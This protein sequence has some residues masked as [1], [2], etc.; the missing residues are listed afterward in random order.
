MKPM[1][2]FCLMLLLTVS[3]KSAAQVQ[4]TIYDAATNVPLPGATIVS[5]TT[6]GITDRDGFFSLP[7]SDSLFL[8]ISHLGY[9]TSTITVSHEKIRQEIYL[10][11]DYTQLEQITIHGPLI[12]S[13]MISLPSGIAALHN[14][15]LRQT[16]GITYMEK[17]NRLPGIFVHYG[18]INTNRI[19]IRGIGSRTPY[20]TNRVK[21]Y[22]NGIPLTS[23]DGT[24]S[25][26]DID[27]EMINTVEII[28]GSKSAVYGSGLG[29]IIMLSGR[30]YLEEG[31]HGNAGFEAGSYGTLNPAINLRFRKGM[32]STIAAYSFA[33]SDG[34]RQNS[35]YYR[36]SAQVFTSIKT[37]SHKTDVLLHFIDMKAYIPSSLNEVTFSNSPD[38]A[39]QNWLVVKGYEEYRRILSG[40]RNEFRITDRLSNSTVLFFNFY[41]GYESRPF[42]MLDD[43]ALQGGLKN[44]LNYSTGALHFKAGFELMRE[45]Y[46]W[47]IYETLEG[48]QGELLNSYAETRTPISLFAH[49]SY[50][51]NNGG[52]V[53]A[54]LSYNFLNYEITDLEP[55]PADRSG[56]YRYRPVLSPFLGLNLPLGDIVRVYTSI[57]HG[58]SYPG[59][60]ETLMPDGGVNPNLRP[61]SGLNMELGSRLSAFKGKLYAD[62]NVYLFLVKDLLVTERESEA[63]FYGRNAGKTRHL[64]FEA[65]TRMRLNE[66]STSLL[67]QTRL[68]ISFTL[69]DNR[70]TDF[71]DDGINYTSNALPGI[72]VTGFFAG[73]SFFYAFGMHAHLQYR[74]TGKQ[75]LDDGNT[76]IYEAY[77]LMHLKIGYKRSGENLQSDFYFGVQNLFDTHYASMLL[78]N[79]PSFGSNAPRYYYPGQPRSFYVG[80]VVSF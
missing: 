79:A 23:G 56:N 16:H 37:K 71:T 55:D 62:A 26:E 28:K 3:W 1:R 5:G 13:R 48:V 41:N 67:P 57:G 30:E 14:N 40:I 73:A 66:R 58:F 31:F 74:Y 11:P 33:R 17:L 18:T 8:V 53:E 77:N 65:S 72:P 46:N 25:I 35:S 44:I 12:Q 61:E 24:T 49:G 21:A 78:V 15:D 47:H 9:H 76:G 54:G 75:Y 20:G 22:F 70:F 50:N 42:N 59:V 64:G 43:D 36:H 80:F 63:I 39:A 10:I 34:W 27:P 19:T 52:I 29:G 32:V 38:S 2:Q 45:K 68:D 6:Q 69:V 60:E 51:F 4:G 7:A